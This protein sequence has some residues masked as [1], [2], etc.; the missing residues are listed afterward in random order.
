MK[1]IRI[2]ILRFRLWYINLSIGYHYRELQT[3]Q[4][5]EMR[6]E[7]KFKRL[8]GVINGND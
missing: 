7:K 2:L 4:D 3:L 5:I 6:L 1:Y 8:G